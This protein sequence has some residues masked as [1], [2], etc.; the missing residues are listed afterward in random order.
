[1]HSSN[2]FPHFPLQPGLTAG[3]AAWHAATSAS[4]AAASATSGSPARAAPEAA[5]TTRAAGKKGIEYVLFSPSWTAATVANAVNEDLADSTSRGKATAGAAFSGSSTA[6]PGTSRAGSQAST[7]ASST[8][9]GSVVPLLSDVFGGGPD[10][11]GSSG[12]GDGDEDSDEDEDQRVFGTHAPPLISSLSR[13]ANSQLQR[14]VEH[15][16]GASVSK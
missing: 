12:G 13:Y 6:R 1:M 7:V 11:K 4:G 2:G 16:F 10:V 9:I 14:I 8:P 5:G 3:L 15:G